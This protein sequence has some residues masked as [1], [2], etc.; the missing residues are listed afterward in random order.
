MFQ[1][2]P[3]IADGRPDQDAIDGLGDLFVSIRARHR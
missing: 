1:S 2:A 3:V